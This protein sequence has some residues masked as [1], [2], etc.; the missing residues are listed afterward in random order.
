M[1][2]IVISEFMDDGAVERLSRSYPML[3]DPGLVDRPADLIR[4]LAGVRAL[5]VRNR[6]Q[7]NAALL[8]AAPRLECIGRLGVGLDN[9]DVEACSARRIAVFP[10][11]GA[12][13]LAV[14]EYVITAAMV[15]LR[16]AY[17]STA[18][19]VAGKWPRQTLIGGEMSG[20]TMGLVGYGAIAREVA[21]R[22]EAMGMTVAAYDPYLPQDHPAWRTVECLDLDALLATADVLSLHTPLTP[23]TRHLIG[24]DAIARMKPDAILINAAR[25]GVVDEAAL[26]R[27]LREGRIAGAALD[28]FEK[29]PLDAAAG[30]SFEG[31]ANLILTPHI[32]G[33]T[34]ESN[35]R[36]SHK[37]AD[38]VLAHLKAQ[39]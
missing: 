18:A 23:S 20:R 17:A 13:D 12:N 2:D 30:A 21:R 34:N 36:V 16:S 22:A 27:A 35:V 15:L 11:T 28:V 1:Y 26:C 31:I 10:A 33:V 24:A 6:T 29:E 4:A 19:V 37:T 8:D 5:V 3:Y 32:A 39:P 25:G 38:S 14:A 7:V 9:I